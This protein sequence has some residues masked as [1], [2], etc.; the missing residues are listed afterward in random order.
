[1]DRTKLFPSLGATMSTGLGRARA[2]GAL[3][4]VGLPAANLARADS[5]TNEVWLTDDYVVRV[6][7]DA[8]L[9]LHREAVLSQ[10]LPE[11]VGYPT[12]IQHGGETGSD[13]LVVT[14]LPGVPLSRA[15]PDMTVASRR[16]AVRQIAERLRAVHRTVCPRLDGLHDVPQLLDPAPTGSQAVQRL[17]NTLQ[18]AASWPHIDAGLMADAIELVSSTASALTP[19]DVPTIVHGDLSF[20]NI[21]WDGEQVTALLDFEFA[22]P[23]PPDLDLDVLMRFCALPHLHVPLAYEHLTRAEDYAEVPWWFAED[24]PELFSHPRQF[25]RVKL[26]SIAWDVREL[27]QFPPQEALSRLHKHHPYQRLSQSLRGTHYL[28]RFNGEASVH[29]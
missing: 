6:N 2:L 26:Y 16:E 27:L 23:G 3:A 24:Y 25:E 5:V 17:L 8:S 29:Y 14:R 10:V 12:L 20:E 9:R 15:W 13:W 7:R 1:M 4:A 21:L 18:R 19:F 22:R 28:D 11:E